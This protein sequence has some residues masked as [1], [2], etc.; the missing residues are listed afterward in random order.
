MESVEL[1]C[2]VLYELSCVLK[3]N[4]ALDL[5]EYVATRGTVCIYKVI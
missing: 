2:T 5:P 4:Y 3:G 1:V